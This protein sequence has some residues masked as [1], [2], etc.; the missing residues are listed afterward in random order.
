MLLINEY[1]NLLRLDIIRID[2]SRKKSS[3]ISSW[4]LGPKGPYVGILAILFREELQIHALGN[5]VKVAVDL[6]HKEG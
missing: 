3:F 4:S 5:V 1:D 2:R 6:G